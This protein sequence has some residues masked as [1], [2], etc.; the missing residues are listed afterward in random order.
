MSA[1]TKS[2]KRA[3]DILFESEAQSL[4]TGGTLADRQAEGDYPVNEYAVLLIEGVVA[5]RD[6]LD[7]II[8]ENANDWTLDRMPAVDRNLL[9]IGAF[10]ILYVDDVPDAVA[11]SEAVGLASDLSTDE[12]P[13]FVNG[14]LSRIVELKPSLSV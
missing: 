11:V 13:S 12:S 3:L 4:P 8:A 6:R 2:R 5:H 10:E 1:R 7:E 9:R 14:L